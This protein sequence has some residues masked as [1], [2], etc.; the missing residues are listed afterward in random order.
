MTRF[1]AL[2]AL[3]MLLSCSGPPLSADR[4]LFDAG[5]KAPGFG[6]DP[7][8]G[9]GPVLV[10]G[11]DA[12]VCDPLISKRCEYLARC[13]LIA[14]DSETASSCVEYFSATWCGPTTW[15]PRTAPA[16]NTLRFDASKAKACADA[17]D[18]RSCAQ[19]STLPEV[20]G[21]FVVPNAQLRQPCYDG[22]SEC[23]EGVCRGISCGDRRCRP[24][25]IESEDCRATSDCASG[26]YCRPTNTLGVG[27]CS[28]PASV[29]ETCSDSSVCTEGLTCLGQC[30]ALP[31][32]GS[33]CVK[34][35]CD[36]AGYCAQ[37]LDGG[38]CSPRLLE[39]VQC[40]GDGQCSAG[41]IC[42]TSL[43]KCVPAMVSQ[44]G[45]LCSAQQSCVGGLVCIG[46]MQTSKSG[47]ARARAG[48]RRRAQARR[49]VR[50]S[51]PAS[52]VVAC[53]GPK[54]ARRARAGVIARFSWA[55]S[56]AF[57]TRGR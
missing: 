37:G 53:R 34:G 25:G 23:A 4:T 28:K 30:L 54:P 13:G 14:S 50:T 6:T 5:L 40:G 41:T 39:G 49:S 47:C 17:F 8:A 22:Y 12:G 20:C 42:D 24:L 21:Q 11:V 51:W 52:A 57:A 1:C 56:R 48:P 29:G 19:W 31:A 10:G 18:A 15:L 44:P 36:S 43:S 38:F 32:V 26:L 3:M 7:D 2:S 45:G 9:V 27:V 35:R 33:A 16:V 55:A 46:L